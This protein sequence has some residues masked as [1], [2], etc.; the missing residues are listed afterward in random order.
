[1]FDLNNTIIR[2]PKLYIIAQLRCTGVEYS[3]I[4]YIYQ[5][6]NDSNNGYQQ[7]NKTVLI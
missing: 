5:S 1:M 7:W 6:Q 3:R 4:G 2:Q